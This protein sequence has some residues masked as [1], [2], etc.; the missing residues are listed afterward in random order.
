MSFAQSALTIFSED[1]DKFFLVLNGQ[2]QNAEPVTNIHIDGLTQPFYNAKVI[3]ADKTKPEISKNL[4]VQDPTTSAFAD[5]TYKIKRTNSGDLKIRYFSAAPVAPNYVPPADMYV[6][7]FG[8]PAPDP[9][10]TTVTQTTT[11][12]TNTVANPTNVSFNAGNGGVSMSIN[13]SDPTTGGTGMNMNMNI[14]DPNMSSNATSTTTTHTTTTRTSSS[15]SSTSSNY[16]TQPAAP[17]PCRY[18][19]DANSFR[20]AKESVSKAS[21]E[22]T[23]LSTARTI[24]GS[25]CFSSDQV[26]A[27][28]SL[29]SF[30]QTKLEFAKAA[31]SKCTDPGNYFKVGNIFTFDA[32]KT[33]LNEYIGG[34]N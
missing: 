5:V 25:N 1:G 11:T 15:Y 2:K 22:E 20:S 16:D 26:I 21:F 6:M 29:F 28:C 31:Y 18:A 17:A 12:T 30:E 33:E 19:M 24:M 13:V 34:G 23:K 27:I 9:V 10:S 7:H 3:F 8:A 32:S 14:N 4:A